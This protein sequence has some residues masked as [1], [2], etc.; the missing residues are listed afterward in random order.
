MYIA[1]IYQY[2]GNPACTFISICRR[3]IIYVGAS[4]SMKIF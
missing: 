3:E 1:D 2:L 4:A